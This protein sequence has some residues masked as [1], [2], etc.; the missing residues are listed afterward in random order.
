MVP[1]VKF[2]GSTLWSPTKRRVYETLYSKD[3]VDRLRDYVDRVVEQAVKHKT[4]VALVER[5]LPL[6][7]TDHVREFVTR[8][9]D[10]AKILYPGHNVDVNVMA[11]LTETR[12]SDRSTEAI[13]IDTFVPEEHTFCRYTVAAGGQIELNDATASL[14]VCSSPYVPA[15]R[16]YLG[17]P[18]IVRSWVIGVFCIYSAEPHG[19]TKRDRERVNDWAVS[20]SQAFED[21]LSLPTAGPAKPWVL[22][23]YDFEDPPT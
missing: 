16:S 1:A 4:R 20:I 12:L 22:D 23:P 6:T 7:E 13:P 10:E 11:D 2:P 3:S 17:A 21:Q 9:V 19:W 15:V 8:T 14:L 18:L 5:L